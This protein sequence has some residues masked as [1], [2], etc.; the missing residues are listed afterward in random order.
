M[1][2]VQRSRLA[3]ITLLAAIS[4]LTG[5]RTMPPIVVHEGPLADRD[6]AMAWVKAANRDAGNFSEQLRVEAVLDDGGELSTKLTVT[7]IAKFDGRAEILVKVQLPGGE[8]TPEDEDGEAEDEDAGAASA[9]YRVKVKK[10][11]GDWIAGEDRFD[12]TIG[13]CTVVVGV[14]YAQVHAVGKDF[15]LDYRVESDLPALRPAGGRVNF[16]GAFY[17][18]TLPVPRGRLTGTLV[19][20]GPPEEEGGEPVETTI[21]LEGSAYVEHRASDLAPYRMATKWFKM[22]ELT[23]ERTVVLSAFQRTAE[24]GGGIQG[25]VLVASDDGLEAYEGEIELRPREETLDADTTYGVP[26]LVFLEGKDGPGFRGV[27]RLNT[28]TR[29]RDDIANL[30]TLERIVVKRLMKP[31][32]YIF[33]DA[34]FLFKVRESDATE[35]EIPWR[36]QTTFEFQQLNPE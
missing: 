36:G 24:L 32:T 3:P 22:R 13:D 30:S 10:D 1:T 11:R 8:A 15:V 21:D 7:N 17:T 12:A 6:L 26:A 14:G 16:G 29:R 2:G 18:T 25:W 33:D 34:E 31:F 9:V 20:R 5:C 19:T 23:S 35:D 28:L 4:L 27:V